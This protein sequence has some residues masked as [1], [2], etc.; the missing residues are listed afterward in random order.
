MFHKPNSRN[1]Q[2]IPEGT[3]CIVL[4]QYLMK[5]LLFAERPKSKFFNPSVACK[6]N[7]PYPTLYLRKAEKKKS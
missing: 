7:M 2:K 6:V 5:A 4:Y 3:E 1:S